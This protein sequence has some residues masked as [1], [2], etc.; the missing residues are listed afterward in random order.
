MLLIKIITTLKY[1]GQR[2]R[3]IT[4]RLRLCICFLFFRHKYKQINQ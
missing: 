1:K 2:K 3:Y 4:N